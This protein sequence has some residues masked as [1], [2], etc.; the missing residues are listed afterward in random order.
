[1]VWRNQIDHLPTDYWPDPKPV[2]LTDGMARLAYF[3]TDTELRTHSWLLVVDGRKPYELVSGYPFLSVPIPA[4]TSLREICKRYPNHVSGKMLLVFDAAN[5]SCSDIW[6]AMP[7]DFKARDRIK[8]RKK[9]QFFGE[10]ARRYAHTHLVRMLKME[11]KAFVRENFVEM[12][13]QQSELFTSA[14][15]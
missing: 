8:A 4:R 13:E 1:M 6:A 10:N 3:G 11:K 15:G 7:A 9:N 5:W 14:G 2:T 12:D